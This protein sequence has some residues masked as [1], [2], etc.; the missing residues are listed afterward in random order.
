MMN[1]ETTQ[2]HLGMPKIINTAFNITQGQHLLLF[3]NQLFNITFY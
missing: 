2:Q 3:C 1:D